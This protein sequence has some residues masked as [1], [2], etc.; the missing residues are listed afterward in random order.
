[1]SVDND[2]QSGDVARIERVPE[3]T[4]ALRIVRDKG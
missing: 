2:K 3:Q 1:M 4:T